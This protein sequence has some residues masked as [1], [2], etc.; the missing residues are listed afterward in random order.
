M[1]YIGT[2]ANIPELFGE[3]SNSDASLDGSED[4]KDDS[5]DG[6]FTTIDSEHSEKSDTTLTPKYGNNYIMHSSLTRPRNQMMLNSIRTD[7]SK[8]KLPLRS[9]ISPAL[10]HTP[11]LTQKRY[12]T[13]TQKQ[14][15][16]APGNRTKSSHKMKMSSI[17]KKCGQNKSRIFRSVQ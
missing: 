3:D 13:K 9:G 8:N 1:L 16:L 2:N 7:P 4:S 15:L 6:N 14:K 10:R 17:L 5:L 11:S 12:L